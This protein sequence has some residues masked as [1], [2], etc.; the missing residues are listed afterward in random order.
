MNCLGERGL[1]GVVPPPL[2]GGVI[3]MFLI[4]LGRRMSSGC[5]EV[6]GAVRSLAGQGRRRPS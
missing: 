4:S 2:V 1:E 6:K 3:S 5:L